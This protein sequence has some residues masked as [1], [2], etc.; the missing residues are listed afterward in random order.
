MTMFFLLKAFSLGT[1]VRCF[2]LHRG[3]CD[4][5]A[6]VRW[7]FP[8]RGIVL[9]REGKELGRASYFHTLKAP[10][11]CWACRRRP[12]G[13]TPEWKF[14]FRASLTWESNPSPCL[15]IILLFWVLEIFLACT[16][17]SI[18]VVSKQNNDHII[19]HHSLHPWLYFT[20]QI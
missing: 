20:G 11:L 9:S 12:L 7:P 18:L 13:V 3:C 14:I 5:T 15:S 4:S 10:T 8:P 17:H 2:L 6:W 19:P 16:V 1:K